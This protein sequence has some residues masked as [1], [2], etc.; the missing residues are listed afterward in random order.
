MKELEELDNFSLA[1]NCNIVFG[2]DFKVIFDPELDDN[3][4]N[5]KRIGQM[6]L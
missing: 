3:D 4:G 2:G 6:H 5:P 1:K